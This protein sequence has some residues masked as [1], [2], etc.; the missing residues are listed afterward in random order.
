[1]DIEAIA[2]TNGLNVDQLRT[3]AAMVVTENEQAWAALEGDVRQQRGMR[4]ALRQ[5]VHENKKL[6]QSGCVQYEG[7]FVHVPRYT[8]YA[9]MGY[10]KLQKEL[11]ALPGPDA[12][13][14]LVSSGR[15]VFFEAE[16]DGRWTKHYNPSLSSGASFEEGINTIIIDQLPKEVVMVEGMDD[17]AFF[18]VWDNKSPTYP[19]GSKNYRYGKP[20]PMNRPERETV[21]FGRKTGDKDFTF[22]TFRF[23]GELAKVQHS[24]YVPGK[25]ALYPGRDGVRAYGKRNITQFV[26][27]DSVGADF[28]APP[29]A[30]GEEGPSGF[31]VD[32]LGDRLLNGLADAGDFFESIKD[33]KERWTAFCGAPVEVAHIDEDERGNAIVVVGDLDLM[34]TATA[35]I[36][37]PAAQAADIDWGIGTVLFVVGSVWMTRDNEVR[38]D[39]SGCYPIEKSEQVSVDSQAWDDENDEGWED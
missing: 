23:D 8:D 24:T 3:K 14:S 35:D 6:A 9:E 37:I 31:M 16:S 2:K 12:I 39:C 15:I 13:D 18:R 7:C 29:I 5:M 1:M 34:S 20:E 32:F 10:K 21:F 19:S 36:R 30:M 38:F 28:A 27:D 25:I 26:A 11:S 22:L 4:I 17:M 33:T